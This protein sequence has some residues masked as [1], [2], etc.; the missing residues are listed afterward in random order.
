MML[1]CTNIRNVKILMEIENNIE[2]VAT[3]RKGNMYLI[4]NYLLL[5]I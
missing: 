2:N 1:L 5:H 4:N 3:L